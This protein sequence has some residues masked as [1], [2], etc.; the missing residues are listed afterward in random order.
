VLYA[1]DIKTITSNISLEIISRRCMLLFSPFALYEAYLLFEN[2]KDN[3]ALLFLEGSSGLD[4]PIILKLTSAFFTASYMLLI[5]SYPSKKIFI[6]YSILYIIPIIPSLAIGNRMMI[7]TSI[8]FILWYVQRMYNYRINT[9]RLLLYAVSMAILLQI[10]A[11]YRDTQEVNIP[12]TGLLMM[13]FKS[14]SISFY[15]I[16]LMIYF[17]SVLIENAYP[18]M[19]DSMI[20]GFMISGQSTEA[21]IG[22]SSLGHHLTYSINPDYYFSGFSLGTSYIAETYEFGLWGLLIGA[23]LLILFIYLL[24]NKIMR[25]KFLIPFASMFFYNIVSSPRGSLLP[26][27]YI[28]LKFTVLMAIILIVGGKLIKLRRNE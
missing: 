21:I 4:I 8:L 10:V 12:F 23:F 5:A 16:P 28:I 14:Q 18:Y 19:L 15:I 20:S 2:L 24:D 13:F 11:F 26:S 9:G 17:D 7:V 3:R 27:I 6:K 1:D 25:N 22:R